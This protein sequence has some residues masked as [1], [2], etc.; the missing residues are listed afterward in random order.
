MKAPSGARTCPSYGPLDAEIVLLGESPAYNEIR[1]QQPFVGEAGR[2][3]N[4]ALLSSG[5]DRTKC[6]LVNVVPARAPGD[7]F[8]RHDPRDLAW[9][10]ELL[11]H[12]L[13][14]LEP[15]DKRVVIAM[16]N[17]PLWATLGLSSITKWRGS[18]WEPESYWSADR[19]DPNEYWQRLVRTPAVDRGEAAVMPTFHP[20]AVSR[21]FSW[22][23][24]LLNDLRRAKAW[25]AG[26][27]FERR[28]RQWYYQDPG[29]FAA[30]VE[31]VV[32]HEHMVAVDTEMSPEIIACVT[33]DEVHTFLAGPEYDAG[34]RALLTAPS[35]LKV[36]HNMAHDW[37][38]FELTQ[39][40]V[41]EPP[42]YDTICAAHILEPGGIDP[43]GDRMVSAGGQVVGKALSPHISSRFTGW[44][45][46]KWLATQDPLTYC[47][48]DT[49]V[50]YDAYWPQIQ[51]LSLQQ[52]ELVAFDTKLWAPLYEMTRRGA[53]VD[54]AEREAT[55]EQL[56]GD[57]LVLEAKTRLLAKPYVRKALDAKR[58]NKPH[59]FERIRT[60][61]CCGNGGTKRLACW[62]CAGFDR[63]PTKVMLVDYL[64]A[65]TMASTEDDFKKAKRSELADMVLAPC[66]ACSAEG[67]TVET[68]DIDLDSP[69]QIADILYRAFGLVPRR[70]EGKETIRIDQVESMLSGTLAEPS[71]QREHDAKGFID[72]YSK[73][74][75]TNNDL[76]TTRRITPGL[77]GRVRC[78]FDLW[79]TPTHRVASREG[80]LEPGT[81]LQNIPKEAR[82][83]FVASPDHVLVYPDYAQVEGRGC[84][85]LSKDPRLLEIYL[86]GGDSHAEVAKLLAA[87]GLEVTRDMA[88]RTF[89][90]TFYGIEAGHL[91]TILGISEHMAE[92]IIQRLYKVFPGIMMY[93]RDVER[94]VRQ[95]RSV[96]TSTGWTRRWLSHVLETRGRRRGQVKPKILKEALATQPQYIG[97][98]VM[99]EGLLQL[100]DQV[101]WVKPI[102][103]IHDATL[104]EVPTARIAEAVP[105]IEDAMAVTAWDMTFPVDASVG[106]NWYVASLS[107]SEKLD[108]GY[109]QWTRTAIISRGAPVAA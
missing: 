107:D 76:L 66:E 8:A 106:P 104:L 94:S 108:A 82:K 88:K 81:N 109:D 85:V 64:F 5:I 100:V 101:P 35:V 32:S 79:Y 83:L 78:N 53:A 98:R 37:R 40:I 54:L 93:R 12:E 57:L 44:P 29:A 36:A 25:L 38:W 77:D 89:F 73:W 96:T 19:T 21:Q 48:M 56:S 87:E 71:T 92:G 80:L 74:C 6:R 50:C 23:I 31:R 102:V 59:L 69:S 95:T 51:E 46:H 99:G 105:L 49:V 1:E 14:S 42:W 62:S 17:N 26:T 43:G 34:L 41:V 97:A 55:L 58:M 28:R 70:Y 65:R 75:R 27:D 15:V 24:W 52:Q 67:K 10:H 4:Q 16:G 20:A 47:G 33:E 9:G 90:A 18:L 3:L 13:D 84:A 7:E 30:M 68:S 45:Y 61:S 60:C 2:V 91:A 103:H 86:G 11:Q 22:H 63:A 72:V 39:N